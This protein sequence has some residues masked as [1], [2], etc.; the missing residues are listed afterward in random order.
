MGDYS[1]TASFKFQV[2]SFE[3]QVLSHEPDT[4]AASN[5][6]LETQLFGI[7]AG[8]GASTVPKMRTRKSAAKRMEYTGTGKVKFRS[9]FNSHLLTR[10]SSRRKRRLQIAKILSGAFKPAV[11]AMLPYGQ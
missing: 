6:K 3:Y 9:N 11:K 1:V 4:C 2:S 5:L 10:K 7:F 8:K